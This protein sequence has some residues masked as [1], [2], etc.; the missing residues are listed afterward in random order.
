MKWNF[1]FLFLQIIIVGINAQ[2]F[3]K[4]YGIN[5]DLDYGINCRGSVVTKNAIFF[6]LAELTN[7]GWKP[8]LYRADLNGNLTNVW[9]YENTLGAIHMS[10]ADY[11]V[12]SEDEKIIF[13]SNIEL[14][15]NSVVSGV[16]TSVDTSGVIIW[17]N[18]Y[19]DNVHDHIFYQIKNTADGGFILTGTASLSLD[20]PKIFVLKID[21]HGNEEWLKYLGVGNYFRQGIWIN[22]FQ[23]CSG[24]IISGTEDAAYN[25]PCGVVYNIDTLGNLLNWKKYQN[26]SVYDNQGAES[27]INCSSG[28]FLFGYEKNITAIGQNQYLVIP[29]LVRV[30]QNL[31]TL[32]TCDLLSEGNPDASTQVIKETSDGSYLVLGTMTRPE[33]LATGQGYL[34][35][36]DNSG[37]LL[38]QRIYRYVEFGDNLL[39]DLDQMPNGG[40]LCTGW[41]NGMPAF[42]D[43]IPDADAWL[44]S[45]DSEGCIEPGCQDVNVEEIVVGL[46]NTITVFPNPSQDLVKLAFAFPEGYIPNNKNEIVIIDMQGREVVRENIFLF[47]GSNNN[48]EIDISLLSSGM[49]TL[50]WLSDKSWLDSSKILVE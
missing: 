14:F 49:Y 19:G 46:E 27:A 29:Q 47:A 28:G 50:H 20:Y 30:N 38:W 9:N 40:W 26:W 1:V 12:E 31:D 39:F 8:R 48:I 3:N 2:T 32:W 34:T 33:G 35:K 16:V 21:Q 23:D 18:I 11:I 10:W 22:E 44:V 15:S 17:Q 13:C 5:S 36:V 41:M 4:R 25:N 42:G 37:E 24:Y 6:Q 45:V 43:S 7:N